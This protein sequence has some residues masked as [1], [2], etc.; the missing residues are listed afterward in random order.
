VF[1]IIVFADLLLN[2]N[3]T[4]NQETLNFVDATMKNYN[5]MTFVQPDP[6]SFNRTDLVV[7]LGNVIDGR[8]WDG[9]DPNY[10]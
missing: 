3:D 1:R 4:T 9:R 7:I 5:N 10:F 2:S 6:T 8:E